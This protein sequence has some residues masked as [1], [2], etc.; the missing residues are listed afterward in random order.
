MDKGREVQQLSAARNGTATTAS[1]EA[2]A[3]PANTAPSAPVGGN[4]TAAALQFDRDD[5]AV[6]ET[7]WAHE[8]HY[9]KSW[10]TVRSSEHDLQDVQ[11]YLSLLGCSKPFC[12][13]D[14]RPS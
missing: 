1:N 9:S 2:G 14:T 7:R 5:A 8:I 3:A 13:S 6:A 12:V 11:N 4:N 10:W